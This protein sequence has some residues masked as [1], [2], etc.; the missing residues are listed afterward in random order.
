MPS[1]ERSCVVH[2]SRSWLCP[3]ISQGVRILQP[4]WLLAVAAPSP[5]GLT[6]NGDGERLAALRGV[7]VQG[8]AAHAD[9]HAL[10]WRVAGLPLSGCCARSHC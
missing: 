3:W 4:G 6:F 10:S 5:W 2:T 8:C 7:G 1:A 9:A